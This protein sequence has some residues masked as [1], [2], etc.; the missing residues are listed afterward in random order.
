VA[1]ALGQHLSESFYAT[2]SMPQCLRF[3]VLFFY[4]YYFTPT[5]CCLSCCCCCCCCCCC[6]LCSACFIYQKAITMLW[7]I[8]C[9]I[10][11][12][13]PWAICVYTHTDTLTYI[14]LRIFVAPG[15]TRFYPQRHQP[16]QPPAKTWQEISQH[17]LISVCLLCYCCFYSIPCSPQSKSGH[18]KLKL[19]MSSRSL[20]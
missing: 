4:Y 1:P 13:F 9:L 6:Q 2:A 3:S 16:K 17:N 15:F 8:R 14:Y 20:L 10:P 7:A 5:S 18:A 19:E 12:M 11:A